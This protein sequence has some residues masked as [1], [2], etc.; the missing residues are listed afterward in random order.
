[1]SRGG[2]KAGGTMLPRAWAKI[3]AGAEYAGVSERT[4]RTWLKQGL[5]H[6]R[7]ESG[8]ILVR[9]SAI[10]EFLESFSVKQDADQI[11]QLV[12]EI[13]TPGG[14]FVGRAERQPRPANRKRDCQK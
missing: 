3:P 5:R 14:S 1:M 13:L 12:N 4:F 2:A 11:D 9:L 6:S 8:T 7:L 10:D